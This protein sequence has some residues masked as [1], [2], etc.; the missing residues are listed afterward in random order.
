MR[1]D[2][3]GMVQIL[4]GGLAGIDRGRE[5]LLMGKRA[6]LLERR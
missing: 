6:F 3:D 5:M 4:F 1:R 2:G